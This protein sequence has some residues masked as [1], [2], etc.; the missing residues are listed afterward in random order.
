MAMKCTNTPTLISHTNGPSAFSKPSQL[1][2]LP[3]KQIDEG[4]KMAQPISFNDQN[5]S[6]LFSSSMPGGFNLGGSVSGVSPLLLRKASEPMGAPSPGMSLRHIP[7]PIM[8]DFQSPDIS[9]LFTPGQGFSLDNAQVAHY[10]DSV[11]P[12]RKESILSLKDCMA[13]RIELPDI[14]SLDV[15]EPLFSQGQFLR[16]IEMKPK[17]EEKLLIPGYRPGT[18]SIWVTKRRHDRIL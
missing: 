16:A 6:S 18:P 14:S 17:E 13:E 3:K 1:Q 7:T 5:L 8:G 15:Q 11:V 9:R 12:E 10:N 2:R 4:D